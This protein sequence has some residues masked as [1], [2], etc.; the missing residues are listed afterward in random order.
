MIATDGAG[1]FLCANDAFLRLSGSRDPVSLRGVERLFAGAPGV[2]EAVFRLAQ[3]ARDGR[4]AREELRIDP[5]D[6]ARRTGWWEI[7]VRPL[8]GAQS[9]ASLWTV[10][11][12]ARARD[13]QEAALQE[14]RHAVDLL[15]H[16]PAGFFAWAPGG[17][18]SYMNATLAAWLDYD[19]AEIAADRLALSDLI[20]GDGAAL[21]AAPAAQSGQEE[22]RQ[23]DLDLKQ[24]GGQNLPARLL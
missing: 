8:A 21:L 14:M 1:N 4:P 12:I 11:D 2:S 15:D 9:R 17:I 16:A 10:A 18:V 6:G 20:A 22:I 5:P 3:A 24:R 19:P 7:K 13:R 23:L